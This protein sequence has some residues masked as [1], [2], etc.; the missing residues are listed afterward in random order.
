MPQSLCNLSLEEL[1]QLFP[2][3][4]TP[5]QS[6]W[7]LWY[8]KQA[9]AL[10]AILPAQEVH[11][12]SH[13]GSTAIDGIWAKPIVDLLVELRPGASLTETK[14]ILM[15][16]GWLCM[17]EQGNRIS[18]NQGYTLQGFAR[19]VYHLHLRYAADHDELYFRDYLRDHP[20]IAQAYEQL[21]KKL[22]KQYTHN[23]DGYTQAKTA[24][25]MHY[26]ALARQCY[27][28]RYV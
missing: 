22:W 9:S 11:R 24:F 5:H 25:V 8:E 14:A 23:R 19:E 7:A 20:D 27:A 4:L 17:H 6:C 2:I 3:I 12:I 18:F 28:G 26:T 1:W 15:Q 21:K 13:I 10:R 16:H